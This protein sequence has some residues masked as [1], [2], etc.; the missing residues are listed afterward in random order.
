MYKPNN[1]LSKFKKY[2]SVYYERGITNAGMNYLEQADENRFLSQS[3]FD[4]FPVM[5][6]RWEVTGED[7]YGTDCPGMV[8]IGDIKQLQVG[9]KMSAQAIEKMVKPPMIAPVSLKN[10]K[11]QS[12]Q[13]ILHTLMFEM[14]CK[15]FV[16]H[17][18]LTS[19]SLP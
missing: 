3:G 2:A 9:E 17:M 14:E 19:T 15:D 6:P 12:F 13:V 16:Q 7:A 4:F 8:A 1:P 18:K 10:Q 11:R 5:A